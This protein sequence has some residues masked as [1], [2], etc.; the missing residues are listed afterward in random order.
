V[1]FLPGTTPG[2]INAVDPASVA[3]AAGYDAVVVYAGTDQSTATEG[4]DRTSL[5]LPGAQA[6][7]ISQVAAANPHTIVYL[8]TL[9]QVDLS[10]F[11]SGAPAIVWSS[12]NGQQKGAA[13]A[14]VLTGAVNP[15]GHLP[16][17]WYANLN[18]LPTIG[19]YGIRPTATTL[20]RTYQYYTGDVT[21]PFGY[22]LSYTSFRYSDPRVDRTRVDADGEIRVIVGVANTGAVP[23]SDVVQL[24]V[25]TPDAPAALERPTKRLA[26]FQKVSLRPRETKWLTFTVK[27]A[28]LAFFDQSG[29]RFQVDQG[30][31]G[32]QLASSSADTDVRQQAFVTVTGTLHPIPAVVTAKPVMAGDAAQGIVQRVIF[33][34]SSPIDPQLTVAL[35]DESLAGYV[36]RGQSTPLPAG[37]RISYDSDHPDV[38]SA[39]P[40]GL[41]TRHS[42]VATV[43]MTVRYHGGVA[44]GSFVVLVQ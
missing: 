31:Y 9:G 25:T 13:L 40:D 8:E 30:R 29:N 43:T 21:Y 23:G 12:Y 11:A 7:L 38:V 28:D 19:D 33:P 26:G 14:D 27:V 34:V 16:F 22:G 2:N 44:K 35:S 37:M 20:G 5:A 6:E 1:D 10:S 24:Y 15:S 4:R 18:Q 32:L 36:T 42:G 17:T 41:R 39:G 3:A